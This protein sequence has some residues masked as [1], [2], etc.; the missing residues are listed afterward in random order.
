MLAQFNFTALQLIWMFVMMFI[1]V[2]F[3]LTIMLVCIM[4][5]FAAVFFFFVFFAAERISLLAAYFFA[6]ALLHRLFLAL[7]DY[8]I[9]CAAVDTFD[10][11]DFV[12]FGIFAESQGLLANGRDVLFLFQVHK[13]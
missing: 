3:M 12:R 5:L 13:Q 6:T 9:Y 1:P 7:S 2:L 10:D 4:I 11:T 8:G